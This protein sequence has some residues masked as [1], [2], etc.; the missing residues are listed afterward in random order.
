MSGGWGCRATLESTQWQI[1]G[2][3]SQLP[4]K[5]HQNR[6]HL[7][8]VDFNL[9]PGRLQG[10]VARL[11]LSDQP[12]AQLHLLVQP[13]GMRPAF[14]FLSLSIPTSTPPVLPLILYTYM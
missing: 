1:G 9:P 5:C 12:V 10:G 2:F 13:R 6:L 8:E 11:A 4:D 3:L 7:G 14:A